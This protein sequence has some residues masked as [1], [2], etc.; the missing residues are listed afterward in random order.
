MTTQ[1]VQV[2]CNR[3]ILCNFLHSDISNISNKANIVYQNCT[4]NVQNMTVNK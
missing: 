3:Q 4:F 2:L 1:P